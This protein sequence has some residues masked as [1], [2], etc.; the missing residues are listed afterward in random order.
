[1]HENASKM[2]CECVAG[3]GLRDGQP[4]A[5][6]LAQRPDV[7]PSV[8]TRGAQHG[9]GVADSAQPAAGQGQRSNN[10]Q[11]DVDGVRSLGEGHRRCEGEP[12]E[13]ERLALVGR[14]SRDRRQS[15]H[16]QAGP[17]LVEAATPGGPVSTDNVLR[18][19][20]HQGYRCALTGRRLTPQTAALDHIVPIRRGG[21]HAIENTQV[22]HKDVNRAKGALTSEEFLAVCREVIRWSDS[23]TERNGHEG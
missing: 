1:M 14:L 15:L 20:E 10:G 16:P 21:E 18:L 7:G 8:V 9:G 6:G 5:G 19:L 11:A 13:E 22:L 4:P 23:V 2:Q 17:Q 3:S 12:R